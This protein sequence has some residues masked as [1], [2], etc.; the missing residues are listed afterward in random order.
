[1][2]ASL[3]QADRTVP[4]LLIRTADGSMHTVS[5]P[6]GL[7]NAKTSDDLV[8]PVAA[9]DGTGRGLVIW[10]ATH[11]VGGQLLG[12]RFDSSG[13]LGPVQ[14]LAVDGVDNTFVEP[15][16]AVS[17]GGDAALGWIGRN[18]TTV[19][20]GTTREGFDL[21]TA[22]SAALDWVV[23]VA[24]DG[25]AVA[26][27]ASYNGE[28]GRLRIATRGAGRPFSAIRTYRTGEVG[29]QQPALAVRDA[30][31]VVAF[32]ARPTAGSTELGLL[33]AVTGHAGERPGPALTVP[34][35]S[36]EVPEV[37][38]A[39]P[40]EGSATVL[41]TTHRSTECVNCNSLHDR[42][43]ID[44]F[45]FSRRPPRQPRGVSVRVARSQRLGHPQALRVRVRCPRRCAV[46][47]AGSVS[48]DVGEF[49]TS[50]SL[51]TGTTV[52]R[53]PYSNGGG[54]APFRPLRRSRR[55]RLGIAVDDATGELLLRRTITVRP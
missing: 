15:S 41:T 20:T 47:V 54:S 28:R 18:R 49:D 7:G 43:E 42:F 12:A 22:T 11:G 36:A 17:P 35:S 2:G 9:V 24:P 48:A 52:L 34:I 27:D 19:L 4:V 45:R 23:A 46:R 31:Y 10:G 6:G 55:T 37:A 16:V 26:A 30:R 39:L 25:A 44:A 32:A 13:A 14:I 5:L 40:S 38:A 21:A 1:M 50:R 3:Q 51:R 8:G 29:D 33:E 53:V